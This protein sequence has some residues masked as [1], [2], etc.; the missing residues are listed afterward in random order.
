MAVTSDWP[1]LL[2]TLDSCPPTERAW[3]RRRTRSHGRAYV[4]L[5]PVSGRP[6]LSIRASRSSNRCPRQESNLDLPLRRRSSCPLD[7]E[8][9]RLRLPA[10]RAPSDLARQQWHRRASGSDG[11]EGPTACDGCRPAANAPRAPGTP[12]RSSPAART[13]PP[14]PLRS[15]PRHRQAGRAPPSRR[16][17]H[18]PLPS[19]LRSR[20]PSSLR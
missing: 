12:R 5:D 1:A 20:R 15:P 9:L 6:S 4:P 13:V 18:D 2:Q 7:Y 10:A 8:G 11:Q 19:A 3:S 16:R 14:P 17:S